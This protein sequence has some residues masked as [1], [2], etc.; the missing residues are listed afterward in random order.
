MDMIL[1]TGRV[2]ERPGGAAPQSVTTRSEV[3]QLR[4]LCRRGLGV[5]RPGVRTWTWGPS[6][7]AH[8]GKLAA[9]GNPASIKFADKVSLQRMSGR[10][11]ASARQSS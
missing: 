10:K 1:N 5:H 7:D 9:T 8:T 2:P 4:L 6:K 11:L 3:Y